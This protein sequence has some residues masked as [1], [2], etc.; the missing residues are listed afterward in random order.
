MKQL[1]AWGLI[2]TGAVGILYLRFSGHVR[3]SRMSAFG[4]ALLWAAAFGLSFGPLTIAAFKAL[5]NTWGY[6]ATP[7]SI[8]LYV[9]AA[10]LTAWLAAGIARWVVESD[11]RRRE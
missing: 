2:V 7:L 8:A 4:R 1:L 6:D 11:Q 3:P 10:L 9:L 5:W